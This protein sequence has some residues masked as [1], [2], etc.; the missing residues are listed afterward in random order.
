MREIIF[1]GKR[2]SDGVWVYGSYVEQY[3]SK[4]IFLSDGCDSNGFDCYH[5]IPDTVGQYIGYTDRKGFKI[6]E[7]DII[8]DSDNKKF[9]VKYSVELMRFYFTTIH[10]IYIAHGIFNEH[11]IPLII[12]NIYDNPEYLV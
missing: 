2:L 1:R 7:G 11:D 9:V 5:V 3:G 4:E 12:G 6:F 8:S 10:P